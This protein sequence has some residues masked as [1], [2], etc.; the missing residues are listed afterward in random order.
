MSFPSNEKKRKICQRVGA[1]LALLITLLV[2]A[3]EV[4]NLSKELFALADQLI[5]ILGFLLAICIAAS[6]YFKNRE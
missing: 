4:G 1:C 5:T 2:V 3:M 6:F